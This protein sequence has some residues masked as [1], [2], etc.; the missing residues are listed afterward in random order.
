[1]IDSC[2]NKTKALHGIK[3]ILN[4]L[5]VP[6]GIFFPNSINSSFKNDPDI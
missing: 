4:G 3:N 6:E 1:M 2:K 5:F